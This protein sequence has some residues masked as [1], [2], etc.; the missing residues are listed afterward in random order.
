MSNTIR[1]KKRSAS[2][3]AGSPS[4]LS[5]SEIAFNENDLKLYYGFGD[6]GSTPPNASSIITIGGSGAFSIRQIQELQIQF[7]LALRLDLPLL[8]HLEL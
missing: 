6:D 1:I 7:Y 5:P 8:L 4:S 3:S 2:G